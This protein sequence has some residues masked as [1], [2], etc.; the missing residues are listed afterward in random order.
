MRRS[1]RV[2]GLIIPVCNVHIHKKCQRRVVIE[3]VVTVGV[4]G[5]GGVG[6]RG[7]WEHFRL[8]TPPRNLPRS[9]FDIDLTIG[10]FW[11]ILCQFGSIC[12]CP[13]LIKGY[14]WHWLNTWSISIQNMS[15]QIRL[16]MCKSW[17]L[18]LFVILLNS[19]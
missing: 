16:L 15:I 8:A 5:V 10:P 19:S 1:V 11:I 9:T 14:L 3:V 2:R 17:S 4:W 7:C 13:L 18:L 12:W 6:V